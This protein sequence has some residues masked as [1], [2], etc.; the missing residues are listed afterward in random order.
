[1]GRSARDLIEHGDLDAPALAALLKTLCAPLRKAGV[2]TVLMGCTHYPLVQA[3]LQA[4]LGP[5]VRLLN[6]ETAVARQATRLWAELGL[7]PDGEATLT[8][9]TTGSLPVF[10]R[11]VADALGWPGVSATDV[12]I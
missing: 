3:Q 7:P 9:A 12:A 1:M 10:Q 5:G 4:E 11:F 8:L 2:D 6:I